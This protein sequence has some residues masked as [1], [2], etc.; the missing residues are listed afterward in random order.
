MFKYSPIGND[1]ALEVPLTVTEVP[2]RIR[3]EEVY[4]QVEDRR[5][6]GCCEAL[7]IRKIGNRFDIRETSCIYIYC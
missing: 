4:T 7:N 5:S 3:A 2:Q 6:Q 1:P